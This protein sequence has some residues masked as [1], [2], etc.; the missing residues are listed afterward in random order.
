MFLDNGIFDIAYSKI[1][2]APKNTKEHFLIAAAYDFDALKG[3]VR[4]TKDGRLLMCHDAG[5]TF[6]ENGYIAKFNKE[7]YVPFLEMDYKEA[8]GNGYFEMHDKFGYYAEVAD[9]ADFIRICAEKNKIA[10]ITLRNNRIP[11]IVSETLKT[12]R[13]YDMEDKCVINSFTYETLTEVRKYSDKIPVSNVFHKSDVLTPETVR[14]VAD[15]GNSIAT[16]F[17]FEAPNAYEVVKASEAG[18]REAKRLGVYLH[19]AQIPTPMDREN[20]IKRG[21]T[22]FQLLYPIKK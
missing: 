22:G 19:M 7:N 12:V 16:P 1:G 15:L 5:F 6:D 20:L 10:Y 21:F 18:Y 17:T 8:C 2:L 4:I 9:F 11:E 13:K 3:D 14:M